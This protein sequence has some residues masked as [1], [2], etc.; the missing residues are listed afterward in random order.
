MVIVRGAVAD[1]GAPSVLRE[2]AIIPEGLAERGKVARLHPLPDPDHTLTESVAI[3]LPPSDGPLPY[4]PLVVAALAS[5]PPDS[6][7]CFCLDL[8]GLNEDGTL[9]LPDPPNDQER[10]EIREAMPRILARDWVLI[11]GAGLSHGLAWPNGPQEIVDHDP[12]T[13]SGAYHAAFPKGDGEK[14][15]RQLIDDSLNLFAELECNH[16]RHEEGRISIGIA[17]P[18]GGARRPELPPLALRRG[19]PAQ[20]LTPNLPLSGL[21]RLVGYNIEPAS[22]LRRGILPNWQVMRSKKSPTLS[23]VIYD[24]SAK[25]MRDRERWNHLEQHLANLR[26]DLLEPFVEPTSETGWQL[27][28]LLLGERDEGLAFTAKSDTVHQ[29]TAPLDERIRGDQGLLLLHAWELVADRLG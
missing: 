8:W 4:G 28:I 10:R 5:P 6:V 11:D 3:G 19:R 22:A 7:T 2:L 24:D 17:W 26:T 16:V 23:T 9:A 20:V 14:R 15:L 13:V 21:A 25:L 18:W 29:N 12:G 1:E 27:D